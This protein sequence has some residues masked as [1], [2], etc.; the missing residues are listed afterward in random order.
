MSYIFHED[1]TSVYDYSKFDNRFCNS[2][3]LSK[4]MLSWIMV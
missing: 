4:I 2:P 3:T 1:L